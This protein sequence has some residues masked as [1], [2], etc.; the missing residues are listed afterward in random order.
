MERRFL[1]CRGESFEIIYIFCFG[2]Q[3][4]LYDAFRIYVALDDMYGIH[5]P[6]FS[7]KT[8]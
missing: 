2:P 6:I 8:I 4:R 3:Q 5:V 1:K 7:R